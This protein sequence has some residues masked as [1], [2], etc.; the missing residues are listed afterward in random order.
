MTTL[1]FLL[2][3]HPLPMISDFTILADRIRDLCRQFGVIRLEAFGSAVHGRFDPA[4]SDIDLLAEFAAP[5][6]P[7]YAN[8]YLD[9][10]EALEALFERK[11]DLLTPGAIRSPRFAESIRRH[12]VTLYE[13]D[14]TSFTPMCPT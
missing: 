14:G 4:R 12:A 2:D 7:G 8:R 5:R 1:Q 10:A 13:A 9:F 6:E 3:V 11:V